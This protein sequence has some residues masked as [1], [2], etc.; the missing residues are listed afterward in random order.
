[1]VLG[2]ARL[3][4][5]LSAWCGRKT[6]IVVCA[7][8]F[9]E[10]AAHC[11]HRRA[12][13]PVPRRRR[14]AADGLVADPLVFVGFY[15]P[16]HDQ[17]AGR[18]RRE[19]G[20]RRRR[21]RRRVRRAVRRERGVDDSLVAHGLAI[22]CPFEAHARRRRA[23]R[24]RALRVAGAGV[25]ETRRAGDGGL[26]IPL[27][28]GAAIARAPRACTAL[29]SCDGRRSHNAAPGAASGAALLAEH[30]AGERRGGGGPDDAHDNDALGRSTRDRG[31]A[32]GGGRVR[33]AVRRVLVPPVV[34]VLLGAAVARRRGRAMMYL[35][36]ARCSAG[37][38]AAWSASVRR[39]CP[40]CC[41]RLAR[42]G[43]GLVDYR[44]A[45]KP[46]HRAHAPGA[47]ADAQ[48]SAWV[49]QGARALESI[50]RR[51][52][53]SSSSS[54]SCSAPCRAAAVDQHDRQ[55]GD[56]AVLGTIIFLQYCSS[57]PRGTIA[58]RR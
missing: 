53:R 7:T 57:R 16:V 18:C 17:G 13:D 58:D 29:R 43:A 48:S 52:T 3:V 49:G 4:A 9:P 34:G 25:A 10:P 27:L 22:S 33:C 54:R 8:A 42:Q 47:A 5:P 55:G 40:C 23:L 21:P 30:P 41:S 37:C 15:Q 20:A 28:A 46:A 50:C 12:G 39:R 36:G 35:P 6:R 24:A 38:G 1:M 51:G 31:G 11:A 32:T 19:H 14:R 2:P 44:R 45:R 26:R 56:R